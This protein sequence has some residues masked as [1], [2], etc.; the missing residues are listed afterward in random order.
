MEEVRRAGGERRGRKGQRDSRADD[1]LQ[2]QV[3]WQPHASQRT[4]VLAVKATQQP[5]S[6]PYSLHS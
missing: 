4:R 1:L 6:V 3:I 2:N 5:T